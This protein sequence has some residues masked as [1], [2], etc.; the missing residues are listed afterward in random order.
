MRCFG[1]WRTMLLRISTSFVQ[2]LTSLTSTP[3]RA[4]LLCPFLLALLLCSSQGTTAAQPPAAQPISAKPYV[5]ALLLVIFAP[6]GGFTTSRVH[7]L[8]KCAS[9]FAMPRPAD[10]RGDTAAAIELS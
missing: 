4:P 6:L 1:M 9:E 10:R 3:W 7:T 5:A 2:D 8:S